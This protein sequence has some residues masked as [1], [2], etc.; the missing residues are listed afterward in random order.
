M[1]PWL[2]E[3]RGRCYVAAGESGAKPL[4]GGVAVPPRACCDQGAS[5]GESAH[6]MRAAHTCYS[7]TDGRRIRRAGELGFG[8]GH[9]SS[10]LTQG[11]ASAAGPDE[12]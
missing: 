7:R 1:T 2:A 5:T 12:P 8:P 4:S 6:T 11:G 3:P 9:R 10:P